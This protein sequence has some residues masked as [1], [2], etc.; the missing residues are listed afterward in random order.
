M[1]I[2]KSNIWQSCREACISEFPENLKLTLSNSNNLSHWL[3]MGAYTVSFAGNQ[4]FEIEVNEAEFATVLYC[5]IEQFLNHISEQQA[6]IYQSATSTTWP[7]SAWLTVTLYYWYFFSGLAWL[8]LIGKPTIFLDKQATGNLFALASSQGT[9]PGGGTYAISVAPSTGLNTRQ[10]TLKKS[11][12]RQHHDSLWFDLYK[13]LNDRVLVFGPLSGNSLEKRLFNVLISNPWRE[14][15]TWA[16]D[17]RNGVNYKP[18]FAYTLNSET[19]LANV[20]RTI[21]NAKFKT[22]EALVREIEDNLTFLK[23]RKASSL[24]YPALTTK[25]IFLKATLLS[26]MCRNLYDDLIQARRADRRPQ[27]KR[28]HFLE[29]YKLKLGT[30]TWPFVA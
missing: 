21:R 27:S 18:G 8:R 20:I 23:N 5:E 29:N 10:I 7:S 16:T 15:Y 14:G 12:N 26:H 1:N 11:K 22:V 4:K 28:S 24:D 19:Q 3:Q 9:S 25:H 17:F 6:V 2:P 13:D 30:I